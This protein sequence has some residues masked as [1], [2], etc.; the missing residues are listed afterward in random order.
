MLILSIDLRK[1]AIR[2][3]AGDL[4]ELLINRSQFQGDH[5]P[6]QALRDDLTVTQQA[7]GDS[8]VHA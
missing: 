1:S 6:L 5:S 4:T 2:D 8:V 3:S 7:A